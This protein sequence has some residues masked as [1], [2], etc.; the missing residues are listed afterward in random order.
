MSRYADC[1]IRVCS[2]TAVFLSVVGRDCCAQTP[3]PN[4]QNSFLDGVAKVMQAQN[5]SLRASN[6]GQIRAWSEAGRVQ[7]EMYQAQTERVRA[8]AD[9]HAKHM[10][11]LVTHE[12]AQ[13]LDLQNDKTAFLNRIEKQKTGAAVRQQWQ[14]AAQEQ[15]RTVGDPLREQQRLR[16]RFAYA[17]FDQH[18]GTVFWPEALQTREF[19][20]VRE[21][22]DRLF[23]ERARADVR[24]VV[25]E[26]RSAALVAQQALAEDVRSLRDAMP[27][28]EYMR[29]CNFVERIGYEIRE[30][31][32]AA[33]MTAAIG[34]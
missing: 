3:P 5:D 9:A 15:A 26:D 1:L 11:A 30:P 14:A 16:L 12:K 27:A 2:A 29:L 23:R 17:E 7:K 20:A 10:D 18:S 13:E 28:T 4:A 24:Q 19:H 31:R 33:A 34:F 6:D 25:A 22:L 8:L 21:V 32:Q